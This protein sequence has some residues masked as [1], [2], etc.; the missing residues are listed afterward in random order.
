MSGE[1]A[2]R[3]AGQA[4][5]WR[6]RSDRGRLEI[7]GPD[8]AKFLHNLTTNDV[9]RLPEWR[10]CEAFVTSPQGKTLAF[11][12]I[13]ATADSFL[14]VADRAGLDLAI[15]HL[16]KYGVFDDV[17]LTDRT[18]ST[19]ELHVAG[20]FADEIL[21]AASAAVP[22]PQDLALVRTELAGHPVLVV[23]E[24]PTG[25][26]GL[27]V[28]GDRA[29]AAAVL[30]AL[31]AAASP[32]ELLELDAETFDALR[33]E[34]GT[35]AFGVDLDE[36]NLPQEAG[37]DDRAI[38]FIKGCYL[39]QE[40]VARIDAIGH[41][42]QH[43]RGLRLDPSSK[44]PS[45]GDILEA[46]GKPAG[47]VTSAA[48]SPGWGAPVA[49]AMVRSAHAT[50]GTSLLLKPFDAPDTTEARAEVLDLPMIP[51]SPEPNPR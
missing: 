47:R 42:N 5:A 7:G 40:T 14:L 17:S 33:I 3:A 29:A 20:P 46:D 27:T 49:L 31:R 15:P 11:V 39:G 30:D 48:F 25:R 1:Q 4:A 9:K 26:P 10:G 6:D 35:P 21:G 41:V 8:R 44:I 32:A 37:R 51:T 28:I 12:N 50:A 22:G 24:S 16:T 23:R 13:L 43:L 38:S 19:F 18:T 2:Y 34:A 36:K 45:R